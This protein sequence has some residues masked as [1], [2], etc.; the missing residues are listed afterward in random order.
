M[1]MSMP[2]RAKSIAASV[3]DSRTSIARCSAL[4]S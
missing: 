4:K 3:A 1:A 2:L